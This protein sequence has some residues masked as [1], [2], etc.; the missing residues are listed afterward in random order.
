[1]V[2]Y[3][4]QE[5]D[6]SIELNT[7]V[8]VAEVLR[9]LKTLFCCWLMRVHR[10]RTDSIHS[11]TSQRTKSWPCGTISSCKVCT[12]SPFRALLMPVST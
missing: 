3:V 1:M 9:C 7:L 5:R 6:V 10:S 12:A 2:L 11:A 4:Q 8:R